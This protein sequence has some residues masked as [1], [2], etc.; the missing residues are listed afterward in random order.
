MHNHLSKDAFPF[1]LEWK[2]ESEPATC[3]YQQAF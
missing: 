3:A 2:L 1:C